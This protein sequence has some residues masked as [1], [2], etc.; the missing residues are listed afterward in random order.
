MFFGRFGLFEMIII[1]SLLI[2][3]FGPKRLGKIGRE[4]LQGFT[5]MQ[6]ANKVEPKSANED[7]T[8]KKE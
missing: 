2:I 8:A 1:L 7:E 6:D 5:S 3:I 4:L